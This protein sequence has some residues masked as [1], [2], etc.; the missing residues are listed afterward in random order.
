[1]RVYEL[2]KSAERDQI[3]GGGE[4]GGVDRENARAG[5]E[6]ANPANS[7]AGNE[8]ARTGSIPVTIVIDAS[9]RSVAVTGARIEHRAAPVSA[10]A[11]VASATLFE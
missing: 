9:T 11:A 8:A 5:A 4:S 3:W 10:V 1:M 2:G 6:A 7:T